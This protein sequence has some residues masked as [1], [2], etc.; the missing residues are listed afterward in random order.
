MSSE[1]MEERGINPEPLELRSPF[2][3][4]SNKFIP[5]DRKQQFMLA[6]ELYD[7]FGSVQ[8]G[9]ERIAD[10]AKTGV[11]IEFIDEKELGEFKDA[12]EA[13]RE[14]EEIYEEI[15]DI[16]GFLKRCMINERTMGSA[17]PYFAFKT[18][19]TVF[20]PHCEKRYEDQLSKAT[21]KERKSIVAYMGEYLESLSDDSWEYS[22]PGG[23][24][25]FTGK[26]P[27]CG[28]RV[29][30]RVAE[31]KKYTK[32]NLRLNLLDITR[33]TMEWI[34]VTDDRRYWYEPDARTKRYVDDKNQWA[35]SKIP[36][37][38]LRAIARGG[39][40]ELLPDTFYHIATATIAQSSVAWPMPTIL[41]S[42]FSLF[43][44]AS[45]RAATE[46]IAATQI[47]PFITVWPTS[48]NATMGKMGSLAF[49]KFRNVMQRN[50][51][52]WAMNKKHLWVSPVPIAFNRIGGDGKMMIPTQEMQYAWDDVFLA[53]GIP[54]G[55]L[56]GDITWAGNHIAMRIFQ[57]GVS[58]H[59]TQFQRFLNK[60]Q[61]SL[62]TN[63][64]YLPKAKI[65]L[66]P[67]KELDDT[68]HK[69]L[70]LSAR[71]AGILSDHKLC[72]I[73]EVDYEVMVEQRETETRR[74]MEFESKLRIENAKKEAQANAEYMKAQMAEQSGESVRN[75][76][77]N[78]KSIVT[79][80]INL[81]DKYKIPMYQAI[82]MFRAEQNAVL[83][84]QQ[85]QMMQMQAQQAQQTFLDKE[86][87]SA[88]H[89]F[90]RSQRA[91][92]LFDMMNLNP[93]MPGGE[94]PASVAIINML[95][96]LP[97]EQRQ[98]LLQTL[99]ATNQALHNAVV[100][101]LGTPALPATGPQGQNG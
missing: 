68:F 12:K 8:T 66:K 101:G 76:Q 91:G 67:F 1:E 55:L 49:A 20:C 16:S 82:E 95:Q 30:F 65:T 94:P 54:R 96:P 27:K 6:K 2:R 58:A 93:S 89:S 53:Q 31:D 83:Q 44:I 36:L 3:H 41:R 42:F 40:N 74:R 72:D 39:K 14:Y 84:Q 62:Q 99:M 22:A 92:V 23:E 26:C 15:L 21:S 69:Q 59:R 64:E 43:Y 9:V 97:P 48:E 47:A 32:S 78:V 38:M 29:T 73:F 5:L 45:L 52:Q 70:A 80:I 18:R 46:S 85:I 33:V 75:A 4:A 19:K 13:R 88:G 77:E 57:N 56:T 98:P 63:L 28:E 51:K 86:T 10:Y 7:L 37:N 87:A 60:L 24:P 61:S 100:A 81:V 71:E 17:I 25:T 34:P 79:T 11:D 50:Y 35:I 90:N